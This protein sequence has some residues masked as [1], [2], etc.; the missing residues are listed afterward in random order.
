MT[1]HIRLLAAAALISAC[2]PRPQAPEPRADDTATRIRN[3]AA[4]LTGPNIVRGEPAGFAIEERMRRY[5]VPAVSVA[6][7][8]GGRIAWARAWGVT[9]AGGQAP[10]DTATLFQAA[11]ISKPVAAA[12]ALRLVERGMLH[13]DGDVNTQLRS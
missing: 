7:I 6:V 4:G 1:P 2:T 13:L 3:V 9:T 11:S 5:N 8:D 10:A 12:A